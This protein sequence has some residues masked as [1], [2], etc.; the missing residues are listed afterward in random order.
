IDGFL[1]G[2]YHEHDFFENFSVTH[3]NLWNISNSLFSGSAMPSL[4]GDMI[5]QNQNGNISD[6]YYNI[7]LDPLFVNPSSSDY[8][9][10]ANS[11]CINAGHEGSALDPDGTIA[12]MG[13]FYYPDPILDTI[14]VNPVTYNISGQAYLGDDTD[15]SSLQ[16]SVINPQNLDTLAFI[17]PDSTGYYSLDVVPGFYLLS[18]SNNGYVPQE[19][20]DFSFSSDTILPD[21]NL[22]SGSVVDV[23]GEVSGTW[24]LGNAYNILCDIE[25]PYG[26]T[27]NIESGVNLRFTE[28]TGMI[29]NG[30]LVANG[31]EQFPIYFSSMSPGFNS[32]GWTGIELY[33]ED[34]I[35]NNIVYEWSREGITGSNVSGSE[36]NN[37]HMQDFVIP[38][39]SGFIFDSSSDMIFTNNIIE[40]QGEYG[41]KVTDAHN[42]I[43]S[44]NNITSP[45]IGAIYFTNSAASTF[46]DNNI[47]TTGV[48]LF[49]NNGE[50]SIISNNII[51][52]GD[53][54]FAIDIDNCD[55]CVVENNSVSGLPGENELSSPGSGISSSNSN[56]LSIL[57]NQI[58]VLGHGITIPNSDSIEVINNNIFFSNG[59]GSWG[60]QFQQSPN[61]II[62]YNRLIGHGYSNGLVNDQ[63]NQ[64]AIISNNYIEVY[65]MGGWNTTC[66]GLIS[67]NSII[68]QDT[69]I[70]VNSQHDG[71]TRAIMSNQSI[72][73]GNY[74]DINDSNCG[75]NKLGRAIESYGSELNKSLIEDN[76]IITGS[77]TNGI[78]ATY[79]DVVNNTISGSGYKGIIVGGTYHQSTY[80]GNHFNLVGGESTIL[81]NNIS[82]QDLGVDVFGAFE[83][84]NNTISS[85]TH[86]SINIVGD[87]ESPLSSIKYNV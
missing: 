6:I 59:G 85:T 36:L 28:G 55:N 22:M 43:V 44:N 23:C 50:G 25:V 31:T 61:A 30:V 81:G 65:G 5:S 18:W 54:G 7:S 32:D 40:V 38:S 33:A 39:A 27:L 73:R 68:E 66:T 79:S 63:M 41:I 53:S 69:I 37:I 2:I 45:S 17:N 19:I 60:F 70:I 62:R 10:Q 49:I 46:E 86:T 80:P 67:H 35:L 77:C 87:S 16:F 11:P 72:I 20:G 13:A 56:H 8:S 4:I 84:L 48:S 42:S 52:T 83:I 75:W 24:L 12:D 51:S 74:L 1:N 47:V 71:D 21:I 34:N 78:I 64:N 57:N 82:G 9:L 76:T 58:N 14:T 26:D 15:H 3:N 29:C